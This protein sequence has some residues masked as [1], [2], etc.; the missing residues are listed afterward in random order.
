[1]NPTII[2][3]FLKS[4]GFKPRNP[5]TGFTITCKKCDSENVQITLLPAYK[6]GTARIDVQIDCNDI[7]LKCLKCGEADLKT[8]IQ[9]FIYG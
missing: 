7:L 1:M 8:Y 3:K 2:D 4:L 6:K 5:G 9:E